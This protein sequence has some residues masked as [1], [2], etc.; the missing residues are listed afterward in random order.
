ML[1]SPAHVHIS[2]DSLSRAGWPPRMTVAAP[3]VHGPGVTGMQ[4]MGVKTPNA[5]AVA[6][7]TSGFAMDMHIPKDGMFVMGTQSMMLASGTCVVFTR[8]IGRTMKLAGATPKVHIR[9]APLQTCC[10]MLPPKSASIFHIEC[11]T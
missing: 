5:A 3:G 8:C 6:D 9:V 11:A 2:I 7:A 1:I 4:G 10:G